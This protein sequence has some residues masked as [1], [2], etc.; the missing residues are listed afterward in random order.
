MCVCVKWEWER[1]LSC[2]AL[3]Q[4]AVD[5]ADIIH[6]GCG[7][8]CSVGSQWESPLAQHAAS[9]LSHCKCEYGKRL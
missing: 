3:E 9:S 8:V 2:Q 4:K 7:F 5:I 6:W 1:S